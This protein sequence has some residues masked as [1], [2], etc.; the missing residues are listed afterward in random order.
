MPAS[1]RFMALLDHLAASLVASG[2]DLRDLERRIALS[3]VYGRSS[4]ASSEALE[5]TTNRLLA[6]G[7]AIASTPRPFATRPSP[8]RASC[9]RASP[10]RRSALPAR[11]ALD[12]ARGRR[13][14]GR[15]RPV[16]GRRSLP[17]QRLHLPQ[18]RRA[19]PDADDL[20]RAGLRVLHGPAAAREHAAQ[21]LAILNDV[22][23]VEAARHLAAR[24]L[25]SSADARARLV[26]GFRA[27]LA[28]RP[29]PAEVVVLEDALAGHLADVEDAG[30]AVNQLLEWAPPRRPRTNARRSGRPTR[31]WPPPCS[32]WTGASPSDDRPKTAPAKRRGRARLDRS[33]IPRAR[34]RGRGPRRTASRAGGS[35]S[36]TS[37]SP[38]RPRSSR[39]SIPSRASSTLRRGAP[40]D[41]QDSA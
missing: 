22:T 27:V 32:T 6:R 8:R 25:E 19:P 39:P 30:D 38:A 37:S 10:A 21:A 11:G 16:G 4:A 7:R 24:M 15:L 23:Y 1:A 34:R 13:R 5:R 14:T 35:A 12:R 9:G 26:H 41:P 17:A 2:W 29:S 36:S 20:R 3:A 18:A 40:L 33:R 31:C 28:R